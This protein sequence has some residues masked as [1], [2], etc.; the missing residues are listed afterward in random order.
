MTGRR[1]ERRGRRGL[2][3]APKI[4]HGDTVADMAHHAEIVRDEQHRQAE[5]VL[6]IEQQVDD[7]GLN[8]DVE[9]GYR[10]VG[11]HQRRIERQRSSNTDALT[12]AAAEGV[13]KPRARRGRQA[14]EV[15]QLA[16]P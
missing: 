4:H 8:R 14:D 12:L 1:I 3:N 9:R 7:L 2:D 15:E 13:R 10:F 5:P 6:K 16:H 11:D